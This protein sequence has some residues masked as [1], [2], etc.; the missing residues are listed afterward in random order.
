MNISAMKSLTILSTACGAMFMPGFFRCLKDNG[1]R[2]IRI[3]GVDT[4]DIGYMNHIIDGFYKVPPI[5][6]ESYLQCVLD[7]CLK[8]H[9]DIVFPHISMELG[10]FASGRSLFESKNIRLALSNPETLHIANNKRELYENMKHNGLPT[11]LYVGISSVDDYDRA[12][13]YLGFPDKDVCIKIAD[14]SGSRGVRVV[15]SHFSAAD[16]FMRQK[17]SSLYISSADMRQIISAVNGREDLIAMERLWMPEYSVDLL[18][19]NGTVLYIGGRLNVESQMSIAQI[20]EVKMIPAAIDLC[21]KI[22]EKLSLT[23]NIGFDFMFDSKGL[24]V[25]T[26]LNPRITA[27]IILFKEAGINFP[28]LRIKQLLGETLPSCTINENI[29][30]VRKYDDII[31]DIND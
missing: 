15:S 30:L 14:G 27:T 24:P 1:E 20:S 5:T 16:I 13:N 3:I 10:L 22:V 23:G 8:E 12:L 28:Y 9:V 26:D 18:A 19:E 21:N 7:I 4:A 6:D 29:K 17:P 31:C 25:L 2:D 11:P